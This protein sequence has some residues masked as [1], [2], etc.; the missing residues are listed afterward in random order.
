MDRECGG[1]TLCCKLM[2]VE[3]LNKPQETWCIHC[4]KGSGCKIHEKENY[5]PSCKVYK[6]LWLQGIVPLEFRPDKVR[7]V[8]GTTEDGKNMAIYSMKKDLSDSPVQFR[9]WII[10]GVLKK[11]KVVVLTLKHRTVFDQRKK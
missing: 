2:G 1:C 9:D 6:C 4:D 7:A 3:E 10:E 5:P 8:V 11:M